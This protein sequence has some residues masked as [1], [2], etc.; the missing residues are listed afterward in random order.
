M[1]DGGVVNNLASL[2]PETLRVGLD[3]EETDWGATLVPSKPKAR[4]PPS[5]PRATW[6]WRRWPAGNPTSPRGSKTADGKKFAP[7]IPRVRSDS[8]SH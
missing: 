7:K 6:G 3:P 8:D 4:R 1:R 2:S 5:F